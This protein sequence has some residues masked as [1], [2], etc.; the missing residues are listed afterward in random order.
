MYVKIFFCL[1][2]GFSLLVSLTACKDKNPATPTPVCR[3]TSA[4]EQVT[5]DT[6]PTITLQRSF[7]YAN[8]MVTGISERSA[9][10]QAI[11]QIQHQQAQVTGVIWNDLTL[12]V[13]RDAA[14][15]ISVA[16][17]TKAGQ[18]QSVFT[19]TYTPSGQL[20]TLTENRQVIPV[21]TGFSG[22]SRTYSFSYTADNVT[23]EH[24]RFTY[25]DGSTLDQETAYTLGNHPSAYASFPEPALLTVV[26][27][28]GQFETMP[29][30]LWQTNAITSYQTYTFAG[31]N[32]QLAESATFADTYDASGNLTSRTQLTKLFSPA[33]SPFSVLKPTSHTFS[34]ECR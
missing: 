4:T 8:G 34:Y 24:A 14:S 7:T 6:P 5:Q 30:L 21:N 3:V 2:G 1:C 26:S 19:M 12:T 20:S 33:G 15:R 28:A 11:Y 18:I 17:I 22:T 23:T 25:K 29:G 32:R 16:T 31:T 10:Q 27:L 13:N 9:K